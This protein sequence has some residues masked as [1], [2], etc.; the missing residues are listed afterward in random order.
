MGVDLIEARISMTAKTVTGNPLL[1]LLT[2]IH[3]CDCWTA[4]IGRSDVKMSAAS[5][6][7][8]LLDE[9]LVEGGLA[10]GGSLEEKKLR[11]ASFLKVL[12]QS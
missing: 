7:S 12:I 11:V 3:Y 4:N 1:T 10:S 9:L 5:S 6:Q 2:C 8:S